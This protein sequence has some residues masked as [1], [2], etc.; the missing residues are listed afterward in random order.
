MGR[1]GIE[2]DD[3]ITE[4]GLLRRYFETRI[5]GLWFP[6]EQYLGAKID[7]ALVTDTKELEYGAIELK[8]DQ[9]W[10]LL[11]VVTTFGDITHCMF[12][13]KDWKVIVQFR[14]GQLDKWVFKFHQS[15]EEEK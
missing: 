8:R 7:G 10:I 14:Q 9:T 13:V 11:D 4:P 1:S 6:R 3:R 12:L 5:G 15:S 2:F